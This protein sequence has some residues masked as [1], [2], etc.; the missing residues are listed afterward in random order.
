MG[1]AGAG[2]AGVCAHAKPAVSA[3]T[4]RVS[5]VLVPIRILRSP[6]KIIFQCKLHDPGIVQGLAQRAQS[7]ARSSDDLPE[8]GGRETGHRVIDIRPV[9]N[10]EGFAA[11]LEALAFVDPE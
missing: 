11:D 9:Q 2:G 10:I 7:G 4:A 3:H 1:A 8:V 5:M 6:S